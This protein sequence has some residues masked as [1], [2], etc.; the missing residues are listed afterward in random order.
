MPATSPGA[1]VSGYLEA[2]AI[3]AQATMK[4]V[5]LRIPGPVSMRTQFLAGT[6]QLDRSCWLRLLPQELRCS[7]DP[8]LN[9]GLTIGQRLALASYCERIGHAIPFLPNES[10]AQTNW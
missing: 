3:H 2:V 8:D 4:R 10:L 5:G 9:H 6:I 1:I 7:L